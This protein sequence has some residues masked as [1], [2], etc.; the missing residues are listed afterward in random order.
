MCKRES[1]AGI[2]PPSPGWQVSL[3]QIPIPW[4]GIAEECTVTSK[5]GYNG[6]RRMK[7]L[8]N[9]SHESKKI[10]NWIHDQIKQNFPRVVVLVRT[11]LY[12]CDNITW[13]ITLSVITINGDHCIL[14]RNTGNTYSEKNCGKWTGVTLLRGS[15]MPYVK[16]VYEVQ[17]F[18]DES[19]LSKGRSFT[20][21]PGTKAAVLPKG[22]SCTANSGTKEWIGAA[23]SHCF[24]CPTLSLA[25]EQT[26]KDLKRS[27]GPKRGGEES[28]FG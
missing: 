13:L 26:L 6:K 17:V 9:E 28:G 3:Q 11:G 22:S 5:L 18:S 1:A 16:I 25:Y 27:Q 23:A 8:G 15:G 7:F 24:L 14:I 10:T 12:K 2:P 19:V 4:T 21:N 20:G